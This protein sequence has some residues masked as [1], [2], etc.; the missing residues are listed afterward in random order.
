M[1]KNF[2]SILLLGASM[3]AFGQSDQVLM[4]I[5]GKN[6]MA[7]EFL[8]IYE[9]NNHETS[10]KK[11]SMEEYLDLFINFKKYFNISLPP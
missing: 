7:S 2:L 3:L 6:I 9:K 8:Y 11:K 5:N 1:K 10:N 4:T